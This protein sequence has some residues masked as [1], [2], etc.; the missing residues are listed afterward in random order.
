MAIVLIFSKL[1]S[2]HHVVWSSTD[3]NFV[4]A[5][6]EGIE[7]KHAAPLMCAG[8]LSAPFLVDTLVRRTEFNKTGGIGLT[9]YSPLVRNGCGPGK[10][11]GIVGIGGLGRMSTPGLSLHLSNPSFNNIFITVRHRPSVRCRPW[12]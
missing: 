2:A 11:V 12:R 10:K 5:I 8:E 9:V 1:S 7:G 3:E 6:P 4:F